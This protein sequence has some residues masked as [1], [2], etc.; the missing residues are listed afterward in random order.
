VFIYNENKRC[1]SRQLRT[2]FTK[3]IYCE[4]KRDADVEIAVLLMGHKSR[5]AI[6]VYGIMVLLV[7]LKLLTG[8]QY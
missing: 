8:K 1:S 2:F 7:N 3:V 6:D 5:L 4:Y